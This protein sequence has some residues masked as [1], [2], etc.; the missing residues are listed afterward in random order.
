MTVLIRL[1]LNVEQI[2]PQRAT[3]V[4]IFIPR[5][6]IFNSYYLVLLI[7]LRINLC[8]ITILNPIIVEKGICFE[9]N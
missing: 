2:F 3:K 1:R 4:K 7:N 5:Y 6:V 8:F 9:I